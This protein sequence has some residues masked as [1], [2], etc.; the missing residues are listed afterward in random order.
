MTRDKLIEL[1]DKHI[2]ELVIPK[3]RVQKAYNYINGIIDQ[4]QFR[5]LEENYGI[6]NP[7]QVVFI[8]LIKKHVDALVGEH[9][10]V[11]LTPS[12]SCKDKRTLH[13]IMRSKQLKLKSELMRFYSNLFKKEILLGINGRMDDELIREEQYRITQD[14]KKNFVSEYEMATSDVIKWIL[15]ARPIDIYSKR[16]EL[17]IDMLAAGQ[18][19]YRA[20]LT[21]DG[22][23]ITLETF[24]PL[25]VF[26]DKCPDSNYVHDCSRIVIRKWMTRQDVLNKYGKEMNAD[27]VNELNDIWRDGNLYNNSMII[28]TNAP[29]GQPFPISQHVGDDI[30]V[31]PGLPEEGNHRLNYFIPVYDV[32][33]IETEKEDGIWVKNRYHTVRIGESI[34][35]TYG[36]DDNVVRSIDDPTSCKLSVNGLFFTNRNNRPYSLVLQCADL[37]DKYNII[38]YLR[39][40]VVAN[41]GTTGEYVDVS[42]LPAFLGADLADRLEKFMAYKKNGLALF[43]SAQDGT[44]M[45]N[46][47][48]NGFD[49]TIK[50]QVIQG[51]ELI[52]QSIEKTCSSITGVFP[53]RLDGIQT[54]DAVRNVQAGQRNSYVI[55]KWIYQQMDVLDRDILMDM[56]DMAK[57]AF[58][59][60][61]QGELILGPN[62]R[63]IFTA[64]PEYYTM[65]DFDIHLPSSTQALQDMEILKGSVV[66]LIKAGNYDPEIIMECM[67]AK[68]V[69]QLKETIKQA[70]EEKKKEEN[71]I[72]R[73]NQ[74]VQELSQQLQQSQS[75]LQKAQQKIEQLNEAKIAIEQQRLQHDMRVDM[76]NAKANKEYQEGMIAVKNKQLEV[77]IAQQHD[78]NPFND[79]IKD[80]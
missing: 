68:S 11:P 1:T 67:T 42:K 21:P 29:D 3:V 18:C 28:R 64:L 31:T 43:D 12:V 59:D 25:N 15:Q 78:G 46:T 44:P 54:Y 49:D 77:E 47:F 52:I 74:K 22:H 50:A 53:Q 17:L 19:Y 63:R 5:Y 26:P 79:A 45:V 20:S 2:M 24:N 41:S 35:I 13:E 7:T 32:E 34:Y 66:E 8:P 23:N 16:R 70:Y 36:K 10:E 6:G 38:H 71:I 56:L 14:V 65:S 9:L 33:W 30:N 58:K 61:I 72:G 4:E 48:F 55:T 37:Q 76:F 51:F 69:T 39:D 75:E 60:G 57:M 40:N 62:E 27:T 80:V 73:L